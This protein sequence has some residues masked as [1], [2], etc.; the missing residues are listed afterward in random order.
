M[1]PEGLADAVRGLVSEGYAG[2]NVTIPHKEAVLALCDSLDDS[3][4]RAGAANTLVFEGG[5]VRG[6]NTDGSGFIAN[7]RDQ[8]ELLTGP[9]LILGA[10][11]A[12]RAIAAALL[13]EGMTVTV[14]NR[15]LDRAETLAAALPGI[16]VLPWDQREA[17]LADTALLVNTTSLGMHGQP[18]L[19]FNFAQAHSALVVADVVYVPLR[20]GFLDTAA[21]RG[22]RTVEGLGMLLHQAVAGFAAWFGVTPVVDDEVRTL[23]SAGIPAYSDGK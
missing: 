22:L 7:V 14:T 3:A 21:E 13:D 6:S 5:T 1:P 17:A 23:V 2:A 12:A 9:A 10:G 15:G 11:G 4:R 16:R 18:P 19:A 20:T 8:G